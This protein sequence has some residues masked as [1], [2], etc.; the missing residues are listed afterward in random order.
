[1]SSPAPLLE[2]RASLWRS[3]I[4]LF[5]RTAPAGLLRETCAVFGGYGEASLS[6]PIGGPDRQRPLHGARP[7]RLL[8]HP[9]PSSIAETADETVATG[10]DVNGSSCADRI[11]PDRW[12]GLLI[13][14]TR[15]GPNYLRGAGI[16]TLSIPTIS[17]ESPAKRF[18]AQCLPHIVALF[19]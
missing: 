11:E 6:N 4:A 9:D 18:G 7:I 10:L 1:V 13:P 5:I 3:I 16:V 15:S 8:F 12:A 17:S 19:I 14:M 2:S